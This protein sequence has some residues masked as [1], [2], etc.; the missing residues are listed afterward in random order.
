MYV[1]NVDGAYL[2]WASPAPPPATIAPPPGPGLYPIEGGLV[3]GCARRE[4]VVLLVAGESFADPDDDEPD[5]VVWDHLATA[6]LHAD[7]PVQVL[8]L[9]QTP[10]WDDEPVV[11][12]EPGE[13]LVRLR[14]RRESF[15]PDDLTDPLEDHAIEIFQVE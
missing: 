14:V 2:L 10:V 3:V 5:M 13:F 12:G 7:A 8:A 15:N 11:A 4:G 9:D 6:P 1:K